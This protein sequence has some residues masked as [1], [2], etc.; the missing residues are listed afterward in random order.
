MLFKPRNAFQAVYQELDEQRWPE[1]VCQLLWGRMPHPHFRKHSVMLGRPALGRQQMPRFGDARCIASAQQT[2]LR[3]RFPCHVGLLA[4]LCSN[5]EA[6]RLQQ[7]LTIVWGHL[8]FTSEFRASS[9]PPHTFS[10]GFS[11]TKA[12][13]PGEC[14]HLGADA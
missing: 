5:P 11:H 7:T 1:T 4:E 6:Y 10:R 13:R 2:W 3:D 9:W 8:P 14:L 12:E